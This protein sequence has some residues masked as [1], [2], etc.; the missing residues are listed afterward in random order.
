MLTRLST[1][2]KKAKTT[3]YCSFQLAFDTSQLGI[4]GK[5]RVSHSQ[6]LS[7]ILARGGE[8]SV[9]GV[10]AWDDKAGHVG[11]KLATEVEDDEEEVESG[12]AD[13]GVGLGDTALLLEVAQG[14]VLAQLQDAT[15]VSNQR[16]KFLR[17]R[18][19]AITY[20]PVEG[21]EVALGLLL[22]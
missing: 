9:H 2:V 20:L 3:Q 21:V 4:S 11:E 22:G 12:E 18:A 10:V 13:E 15:A 5:W 19:W 17:V 14:G 6:P 7:V 1:T 8:Q 16:A